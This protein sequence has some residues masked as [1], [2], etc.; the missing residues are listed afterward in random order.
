MTRWQMNERRE[1]AD[2]VELDGGGV[3][4][5]TGRALADVRNW[6]GRLDALE[7]A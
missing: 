2:A 6:L 3:D 1:L 5:R 4:E 7:S